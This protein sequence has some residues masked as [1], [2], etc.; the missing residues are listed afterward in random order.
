MFRNVSIQNSNT[1]ELPRRKHKIYF[2]YLGRMAAPPLMCPDTK[3]QKLDIEGACVSQYLPSPLL[4]PRSCIVDMCECPSQH[5]YCESFT[6]YAHECTRLGVQLP[7]WR[8]STGCPSAW[9]EHKG[10][11]LPRNRPPA[12]RLH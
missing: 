8:S 3:L 10:H 7:D 6:A 1:W 12:P 11:A 2:F 4:C 9:T 5:C